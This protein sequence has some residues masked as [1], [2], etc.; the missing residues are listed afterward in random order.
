MHQCAQT[1]IL[2][3]NEQS[4]HEKGQVRRCTRP[5]VLPDREDYWQVFRLT[6]STKNEVGRLP[7]VVPLKLMRT[8]WPL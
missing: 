5:L 2:L 1:N 3:T 8:V 4:K 6:S 7:S